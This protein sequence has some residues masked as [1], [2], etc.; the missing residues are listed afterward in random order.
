LNRPEQVMMV[1]LRSGHN[2]L[3]A[4]MNKKYWLVQS[5]MCPC[6]EEDQTTE[7][8][9]QRCKWHYKERAATWPQETIL[10]KML[11]GDVDD[12]RRTTSFIVYTGIVV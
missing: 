12:L 9:L 4:H 6:G 5:P 7:H 8:V 2:R 11:Y 3:Y 1:R 10:Q